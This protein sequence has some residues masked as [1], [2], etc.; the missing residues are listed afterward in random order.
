MFGGRLR[1]CYGAVISNDCSVPDS[2]MNVLAVTVTGRGTS[3][4]PAE[5]ARNSREI[6]VP[7]TALI[8]V[9]ARKS[10][11]LFAKDK[12]EWRCQHMNYKIAGALQRID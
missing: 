5:I 7:T 10:R 11:G 3:T 1:F 12:D 9:S 2:H 8:V 6:Q 4:A